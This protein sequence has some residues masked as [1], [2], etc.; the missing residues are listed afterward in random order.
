MKTQALRTL[1]NNCLDLP[2]ALPAY[3]DT[4]LARTDRV[5]NRSCALALNVLGNAEKLVT[6]LVRD[7][8]DVAGEAEAV[9]ARAWDRAASVSDA[10]RS[11]PRFARVF[12]ELIRIVASYRVHAVKAR[13]LSAP[14]AQQAL[15]AL[16]HR[17][18]K[19]VYNLCVE[20]RGGL[21][22]IG[23][24][25]STYANALPPAYVEYLGRLQDRVP[26]VPYH[27]IAQRIESEFGRPVEQVF[28]RVDPAPLAAASLA[29]VHPAELPDGTRVVIKVQMPD[30]EH[31]AEIDL[32]AFILA[33][34]IT[35]DLF[36]VP[37]L[38]EIS[39]TLADS[40]RRE[41][42]YRRELANINR[43][44][45]QTAG[46]PRVVAPGVYP[47][48]STRRVLTMEH[49][50][51][52]RL[53]P[54]LEKA[55]PERRNRLLALIAESFC[56][57]IVTH[58]FFHAD[59]HPGN[60]MVLAGDRLG[61]IDFGCV[62]DFSAETYALYMEMITAI[63]SRDPDAMARLF[64]RMGFA[65]GTES[66]AVLREMA[67]DFIELLMLGP[68]QSLA[69]VDTTQKLSRGLELIKKYPAVRVPRHFVLLG[70]V[71]L[72][73]GGI[74]MRFNP[75]INIFMLMVGQMGKKTGEPV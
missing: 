44:N 52:E 31:T 8:F 21:I 11:T 73:L 54:F 26:P 2:S 10:I 62:E 5:I 9:Y 4:L 63:L 20:M 65:A 29:Q 58:G 75:D 15:D 30:I 38:P 40:V 72:T 24:F 49:L 3:R 53:I 69:D 64:E 71:L 19:R 66:D 39:R 45:R 67:T 43:F 56:S 47:E 36:P 17:N 50:E 55:S 34:D 22:K 25:A 48:M 18:A 6:D 14:E 57:Q 27:A 59:P 68:E 13:F 7:S 23:Q 61:L 32:T 51:G 35:N 16:H 12:A 60:M 74:M 42:D 1:M 33:A 70:R 46:D 37:G 41:L 28:A